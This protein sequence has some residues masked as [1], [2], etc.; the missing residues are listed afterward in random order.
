MVL[1]LLLVFRD[2]GQG[3]LRVKK[4]P[5]V[6][7]RMESTILRTAEAVQIPFTIRDAKPVICMLQRV[8]TPHRK[9]SFSFLWQLPIHG[10][11]DAQS[12]ILHIVCGKLY[13][14]FARLSNESGAFL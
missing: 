11:L 14:T 3:I 1:I 2:A 7:E 5:D 12:P 8:R 4:H 6:N 13:H 10:T 9:T